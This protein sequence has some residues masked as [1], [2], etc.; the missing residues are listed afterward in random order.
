MRF[1]HAFEHQVAPVQRPLGMSIRR[2]I[3]GRLNEPCEQGGL[4][5]SDVL[6]VLVEIGPRCLGE[7]ADG[8]G[9]ALSEID[10]VGVELE[11][12]LFA[13]LL[14]QFNGNQ[15]LHQFPLQS[16]FRRQEEGPGELHGDGGTALFVLLSREINPRGFHQPQ[17]VYATV[18]KEA[19]ILNGQNCIHHHLRNVVVLDQL[20]LGAL[21]SVEQG[22]HQLRLEFVGRQFSRAVLNALDLA[23]TEADLRRIRTVIRLRSRANVDPALHQTVA[24]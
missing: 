16:F 13:E 23:A 18:L 2:K 8:E 24:A 22:S 5:K 11:N 4:G 17:V 15:H 3:A 20:A 14:L 1:D 9:T 7:S 10:P 21:F 12:L 19:A 6:Q